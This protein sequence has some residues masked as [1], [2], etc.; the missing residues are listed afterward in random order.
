M[1]IVAG[2]IT[3]RTG[4]RDAYLAESIEAVRQARNTRSCFEFV[5]APDPI[6]PNHVVVYERWATRTALDRFRGDGPPAGMAN[7]IVSINVAEYHV[8][9]SP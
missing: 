5:V 3:V 7:R 8:A 4:E 6:E 1:I 9:Q 2:T